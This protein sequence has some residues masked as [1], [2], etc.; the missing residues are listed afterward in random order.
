MKRNKF[1]ISLI[2]YFVCLYFLFFLKY[3]LFMI[4][5]YV[6]KG[7]FFWEWFFLYDNLKTTLAISWIYIFLA[8]LR[9]KYGNKK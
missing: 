9:Y 2:I 8:W 5:V 1:Y 4:R 3:I 7:I 6:E